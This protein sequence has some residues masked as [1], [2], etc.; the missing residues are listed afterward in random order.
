M[1]QVGL[2]AGFTAGVNMGIVSLAEFT[3]DENP[4]QDVQSLREPRARAFL[5][6]VGEAFSNPSPTK[7]ESKQYKKS[8][9]QAS[10]PVP[11]NAPSE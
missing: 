3:P 1:D 8:G 10:H 11:V 9:R 5:K 6:P 4:G 7:S 2:C